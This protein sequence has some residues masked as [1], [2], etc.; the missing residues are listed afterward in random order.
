VAGAEVAGRAAGAASADAADWSPDAGFFDDFF[1]PW[2]RNWSPYFSVSR[3]MTGA[4]IV[5]DAE[6]TYSPMSFSADSTSLLVT[7]NSLASSWTRTFATVLLR[8][9]VRARDGRRPLVD[10][11]AHR[12][13]VIGCS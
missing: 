6:R 7:P 5:D 10:V 9:A 3:R 12:T 11:H 8:G 1:A 13:E 4:S 2:V